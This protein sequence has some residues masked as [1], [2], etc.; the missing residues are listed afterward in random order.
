M[1]LAARHGD[2]EQI[3]ALLDAHA[4]INAERHNLTPLMEAI[5]HCRV[6]AVEIL[7]EN[8][9]NVNA[10]FRDTDALVLAVEHYVPHVIEILLSYGAAPSLF[11]SYFNKSIYS[12]CGSPGHAVAVDDA[13]QKFG[14]PPEPTVVDIRKCLAHIGYLNDAK[15]SELSLFEISDI[16]EQIEK[17]RNECLKYMGM[18]YFRIPRRGLHTI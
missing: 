4:D 8:G 11:C 1:H 18:L 5:V 17:L 6:S 7:L 14:R 2:T 10:A 3:K 12:N 15:T 13:K 16:N 9:A